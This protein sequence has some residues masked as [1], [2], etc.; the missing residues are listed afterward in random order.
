MLL[1]IEIQ[2]FPRVIGHRL[3]SAGMGTQ[4]FF[5]DSSHLRAPVTTLDRSHGHLPAKGADPE[6]LMAEIMGKAGGVDKGKA[7]APRLSVP[8]VNAVM[9]STTVGASPFPMMILITPSGG[10]NGS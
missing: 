4:K 5:P 9:T 10:D 3:V 6:R 7:G 2:E 8:E 1:P